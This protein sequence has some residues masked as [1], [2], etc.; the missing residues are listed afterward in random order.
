MEPARR[1]PQRRAPGRNTPCAPCAGPT[2]PQRSQTSKNTHREG[3]KKRVRASGSETE[4]FKPQGPPWGN[5]CANPG[6]NTSPP[7]APD[8]AEPGRSKS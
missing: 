7:A 4:I 5:R 3:G 8:Q 2:A 6:L 1:H